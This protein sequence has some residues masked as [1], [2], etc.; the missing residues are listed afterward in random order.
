LG[1]GKISSSIIRNKTWAQWQHASWITL[2]VAKKLLADCGQDFDALKRLAITKEFKPVALNAK[3]NIDI[4]QALRSFKSH[5]VI[6]KIRRRRSEIERRISDFHRAL[7]PS[8]QASGIAGRSDF[9][10]ARSIML[11]VV[12]R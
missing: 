4:K 5:N 3:A 7:G 12:L 2:D 10:P 1:Q 6:G 8:R 11:R 9:Q